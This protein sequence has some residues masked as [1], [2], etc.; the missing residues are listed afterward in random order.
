MGRR[1]LAQQFQESFGI[2]PGIG[3]KA[4]RHLVTESLAIGPKAPHHPPGDRVEPVQAEDEAPEPVPQQVATLPVC[5]LMQENS[6]KLF[7]REARFEIIREKE[8]GPPRT[9]ETRRGQARQDPQLD[10]GPNGKLFP[11]FVEKLHELR[12]GPPRESTHAS[13][14]L[15]GPEHDHY[16]HQAGSGHPEKRQPGR[17][18][19]CRALSRDR[20]SGRFFDRVEGNL[21]HSRR[22]LVFHGRQGRNSD[23]LQPIGL[24]GKQ[25]HYLRSAPV[26]RDFLDCE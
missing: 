2:G 16:A 22:H 19:S 18:Q 25:G 6:A 14:E 23:S 9:E 1:K 4:K 21:R 26:L 11:A 12:C 5:Q 17:T 8:H 13:S 15:H 20:F 10:R 3:E 24:D 7:P